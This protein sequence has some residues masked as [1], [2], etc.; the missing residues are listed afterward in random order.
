MRAA[1]K[2]VQCANRDRGMSMRVGLGLV[3]FRSV[4]VHMDMHVRT[5]IMR[6]PMRMHVKLP[7]FAK[8]PKANRDQG[9]ADQALGYGGENVDRQHLS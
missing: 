5:A 1:S 7:H 6:M 2:A 4:L 3:T 8:A 9:H